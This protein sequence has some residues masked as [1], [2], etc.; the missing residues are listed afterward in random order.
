MTTTT[1]HEALAKA[2]SARRAFLRL[3]R[4]QVEER[5]GP[6]HQTVWNIERAKGTEFRAS[7][8]L[9]LD[10]GL[11]WPQGTC[12]RI[13][14]DIIDGLDMVTMLAPGEVPAG[15][16]MPARRKRQRAGGLWYVDGSSQPL[17]WTIKEQWLVDERH[18]DDRPVA[19]FSEQ[20]T[21]EMVVRAVN[22][23]L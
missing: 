14:D 11:A 15:V 2:V 22:D 1:N 6:S 13:A 18:D 21:A 12:A 20:A 23:L 3:S 9:N 5:G 16:R 7:T 19:L 10:V 17:G 4:K 8:L